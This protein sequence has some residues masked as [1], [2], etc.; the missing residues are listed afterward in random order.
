MC[1][2]QDSRFLRDLGLSRFEIGCSI[3]LEN[4]VLSCLPAAVKDD[5]VVT[6]EVREWVLSGMFSLLICLIALRLALRFKM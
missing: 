1:G 4:A 6:L 5:L 2:S 3:P